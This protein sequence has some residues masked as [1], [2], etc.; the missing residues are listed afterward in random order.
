M[1]VL[2]KLFVLFCVTFASQEKYND[3]V[4]NLKRFGES[5][6]QSSLEINYAN[7]ILAYITRLN[8]NLQPIAVP[9]LDYIYNTYT[10]EP[11][12]AYFGDDAQ[13]YLAT[14][15]FSRRNANDENEIIFFCEYLECPAKT[16]SCETIIEVISEVYNEIQITTQ[17]LSETNEVL[18]NVTLTSS[19][20]SNAM[21]YL[22]IQRKD[23][24]DSHSELIQSHKIILHCDFLTCPTQTNI[25]K[26]TFNAVPEDFIEIEVNTQCLSITNEVLLERITN[27]KNPSSERYY[28]IVI[29]SDQFV[30]NEN[31]GKTDI[32]M[33]SYQFSD[34]NYIVPPSKSRKDLRNKDNFYDLKSFDEPDEILE[35]S[36]EI[37][38]SF[39]DENNY[40]DLN[41]S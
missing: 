20:I 11:A 25:C 34:D 41:L 37:E 6:W 33:L 10:P 16:H 32:S 14:N 15:I 29:E 3:E 2:L 38:N 28:Y 22:E 13:E 9:Y 24:N 21:Y 26:S 5:S 12:I 19:D 23:F 39:Y 40:Y 7:P 4:I 36:K 18:N 31:I 27:S 17:C 8:S 1:I 35:S 30:I